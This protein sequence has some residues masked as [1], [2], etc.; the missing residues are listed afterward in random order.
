MKKSEKKTAATP[1]EFTGAPTEKNIP[2]DFN[3]EDYY[4]YK[5][6]RPQG[7][8]KNFD[9]HKLQTHASMIQRKNS[10]MP[11][12]P[13]HREVGDLLNVG[14]EITSARVIPRV[15]NERFEGGSSGS[16]DEIEFAHEFSDDDVEH[17]ECF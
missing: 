1:V 4:G 6:E 14:E 15:K 13:R 17:G 12:K 11:E 10:M 8:M 3:V 9:Q 16:E 7:E 2:L 5:S